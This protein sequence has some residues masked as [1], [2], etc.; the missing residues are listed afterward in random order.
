MT[1]TDAT[2]ELQ[3][4]E[5]VFAYHV[6]TK[7]RRERY[8]A[9][10]ETIDWTAPPNPFREFSGCER[11]LL[12]LN[13]VS[14]SATY[15][16]VFSAGAVAPRELSL[17]SLGMLLE[18]SMAIS[19]W[20]EYGTDR[21]AVRCNPSSGNLHP[22]ETY[23][24]ARGIRGLGDG[25]HHYVV[26]DHAL[27][28][29]FKADGEETRTSELWI[30]LSSVHWREAWK[31]GERAFRYCQIDT[32]HALGALRIAAGVLGWTLRL[33]DDCR[34]SALARLLGHDRHADFSGV[35]YEEADLLLKVAPFEAADAPVRM[36]DL[37]SGAWTGRANML[38]PHPMYHWPVIDAVAAA[39]RDGPVHNENP[40]LFPPARHQASAQ[41]PPNS[42]WAD[43]VLNISTRNSSCP[44][45]ISIGCW[46][47][48]CP[49]IVP[50]G[51]S[52]H[53]RHA[54]IR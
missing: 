3:P 30:G 42:F 31:Y 15:G 23:V 53:S 5:C 29:K 16:D 26:R 9:G 43:A 52:G 37:G 4:A 51:T 47:V 21:W 32:G 38:D 14:L 1:R 40:K 45:A 19:A 25:L 17:Q 41:R 18:L 49:A 50:L 20:K 44:P 54:F 7:H 48:C 24:L 11:T 2:L 13:A 8:A 46:I 10:P 6:R 22:T 39:T 28:Q 34:G 36:P 35:E 12:P 33:V 27:E